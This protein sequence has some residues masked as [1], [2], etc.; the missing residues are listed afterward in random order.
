MTQKYHAK[1]SIFI[2]AER[3]GGVAWRVICV[4]AKQPTALK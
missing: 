2:P 1:Q 4:I 3:R